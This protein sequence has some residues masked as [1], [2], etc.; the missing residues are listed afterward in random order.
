MRE[1][2]WN[3]GKFGIAAVGVPSGV[4]GLRAEVLLA[5]HAELAVPA[6]VP[7][8]CDAYAITDGEVLT[9][10][11]PGRHHLGDDLVAG[12]HVGPVHGQIAFGDMQIRPADAACAHRDQ[13]LTGPGLGHVGGDALQRLGVH[14]ARQADP[15]CGHCSGGHHTMVRAWRDLRAAMSL[16][17][18]TI[19]LSRAE[20]LLRGVKRR[21]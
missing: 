7:Q 8:P 19:Q 4:P 9:G 3:G 1:S 14:R 2:R 12:D 18:G 21:R 20:R 17:C 11:R 5:A 6:R 15:P 10:V 16:S 13:D